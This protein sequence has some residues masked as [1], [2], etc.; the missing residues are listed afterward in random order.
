MAGLY[1]VSNNH[2]L[3]T[4]TNLVAGQEAA[5]SLPVD[6]NATGQPFVITR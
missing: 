3:V 4:T 1:T 2:G 5:I 6:A